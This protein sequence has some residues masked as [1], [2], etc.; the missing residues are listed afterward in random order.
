MYALNCNIFKL[1]FEKFQFRK[2]CQSE[3]NILT[4]NFLDSV[5][6]KKKQVFNFFKRS[7]V[8]ALFVL[9][10]NLYYANLRSS[11]QQY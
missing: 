9:S 3:A 6:M 1:K 10:N 2:S 4:I 11:G 8:R 7:F 5:L